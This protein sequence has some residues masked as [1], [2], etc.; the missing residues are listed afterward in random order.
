MTKIPR[1][2]PWIKRGMSQVLAIL[3]MGWLVAS[4]TAADWKPDPSLNLQ[5]VRLHLYQIGRAYCESHLNN[6]MVLRDMNHTGY[7]HLVA[8]TAMFAEGLL[9]TRDPADRARAEAMLRLVLAKQD[10]RKDSPTYGSFPPTFEEDL[11]T[12]VKPDPNFCQFTALALANVIQDDN[13]QNHVLSPDLRKDLET[14]LG[15]AV[16]FTIREDVS[17][18]YIN[19]SM[20]SAAV[21][22]AGAK[23]LNYPGANDFAMSKAG[24]ILARAQPGTAF[25]EYLAPTYF[26]VDLESAYAIKRYASTPAVADAGDRLISAFWKDIAASYHAPTFQLAG[27]NARSYGDNMLE[28]AA[29]LKYWLALA[30]DG[31]YPLNDT[32][33]DH[34]WDLAGLM[35]MAEIPFDPRPEF[36]E[37]TVPWREMPVMN[38][39]GMILSQYREGDIIVGSVNQQSVWQ[40]QRNVVSYFPVAQPAGT[41]GFCM[42]QSSMSFG[43]G[44]A[45]FY[46]TQVKRAVLVAYTGKMP[47]PAAGG[48]RLVFN[49]AAEGGAAGEGAAGSCEVHDGDYLIDIYSLTQG[50]GTLAFRKDEK[51]AYVERPWTAADHLGGDGVLAYLIYFRMPGEAAPAV[52]GITFAPGDQVLDLAAEVNDA[53]LALHVRY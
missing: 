36:Q 35:G 10:V 52:K 17:P 51:R 3:S 31:K 30:L 46:S 25:T 45:H 1:S 53:P 28:Y 32:E 21:G 43:N 7:G 50:D 39:P 19:I 34:A 49:E 33:T 26:G 11:A 40:Q 37:P 12:M 20:I 23:L 27:P 4:A 47:T 22:A 9:M 29:G 41:V 15:L 8:H 13:D 16:G 5:A 24:W 42:D 44:Y 48:L 14:A 2:D 6:G 18:D 38:R